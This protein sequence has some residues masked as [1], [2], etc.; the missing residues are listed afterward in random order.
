MKTICK[1]F[2]LML[3][4]LLLFSLLSACSSSGPKFPMT[5]QH[6]KLGRKA[7]EIADAYLDFE[8]SLD[9]ACEKITDL[10]H[11][12]DNLPEGTSEQSTGNLSLSVR[13]MSLKSAFSNAKLRASGLTGLASKE[14]ADV[15]CA[16]NNLAELLGVKAR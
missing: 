3:V 8:L 7:L 4:V 10:Y 15:L 6:E 11:A 9:D 12:M 16:R 2:V 14:S 1:I 13:V 5:E